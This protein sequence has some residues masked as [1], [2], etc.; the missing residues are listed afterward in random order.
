MASAGRWTTTARE[1]RW[2]TIGAACAL[3]ALTAAAPAARADQIPGQY[4]VVLKDGVDASAVIAAHEQL[5]GAEVLHRYRYALTGYSA[6]LSS[7]GVRLVRADPLV[8][9]VVPD[10]EA[11]VVTGQPVPTEIDRIDTDLSSTLAGDGTGSVNSDIAIVDSGIDLDHPDLNVAGGVNCLEPG[12][13]GNNGTYDDVFGHGT[14]VAGIA[15]AKDDDVGVVGAA[16][17]ARLWSVRSVDAGGF[18]TISTQLCG[19]D[20]VTAN[21]SFVKV[22]NFSMASTAPNRDDG[23]CG[24]TRNDVLHQAMCRSVA[25]G[26]TWVVA[27]FNS[28]NDI[29]LNAPNG[30]DEVLTVTAVGDSDGRPGTLGANLTCGGR[31]STEY[32]DKYASF[33]SFATLAADQ[34]HTIAAPGVCINSTLPGGGYGLKSGTSMSAPVAT[35]TAALC[36]AVGR[37]PATPA[38]VIQQLRADAQAR[39]TAEPGYGFNGDP[40]RPVTGRYYGYLIDARGY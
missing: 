34:A 19:V 22:A 3:M 7:D 37:C 32:D 12:S 25:A 16:P 39:T 28:T 31:K 13:P 38:G 33:S 27:A 35:G 9:S 14:H 4:V 5:A 6:R 40:T 20:W 11:Q 30:Y 17:G 29:Q 26:V 21:A 1:A 15:A 23:N 8:A 10:Y 2:L 36:L 18:A 24:Y